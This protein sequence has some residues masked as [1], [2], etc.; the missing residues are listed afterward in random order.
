MPILNLP[1]PTFPC[2]SVCMSTLPLMRC[3]YRTDQ[4]TAVFAELGLRFYDSE[5]SSTINDQDLWCLLSPAAQAVL[6]KAALVEGEDV[7]RNSR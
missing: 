5:E 1:D 7:W 4:L 6:L 3:H 2:L